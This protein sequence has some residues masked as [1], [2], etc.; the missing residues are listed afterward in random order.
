[1]HDAVQAESSAGLFCLAVFM[2]LAVAGL[3]Y[4]EYR[5][6]QAR[7]RERRQVEGTD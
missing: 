2:A 1:M 3:L 7:A 6:A 4:V 5:F